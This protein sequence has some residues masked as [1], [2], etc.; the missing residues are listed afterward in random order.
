MLASQ[1]DLARRLERVEERLQRHGSVIGL[2]VD[3]IKKLK[4]SPAPA[5]RRVG[6]VLDD[7]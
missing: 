7:K 3:E 1:K 2:V 6:F 5:R 4:Q